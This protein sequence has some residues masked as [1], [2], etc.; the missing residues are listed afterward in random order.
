MNCLDCLSGDYYHGYYIGD[1]KYFSVSERTDLPENILLSTPL[2]DPNVMDSF[3]MQF[4]FFDPVNIRIII[5]M[6]ERHDIERGDM[7]TYDGDFEYVYENSRNVALPT[8][9]IPGVAWPSYSDLVPADAPEYTN[10]RIRAID[11][12]TFS[13]EMRI[14]IDRTTLMDF[15][16][17]LDNLLQ[18]GWEPH[19]WA[20]WNTEE[21]LREGL[22]GEGGQYSF[23]NM[24]NEYILYF[25]IINEIQG[26]LQQL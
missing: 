20:N 6:S 10:G 22:S 5:D 18:D 9:I 16:E 13:H 12:T 23:I 24:D 21:A 1:D 7:Y 25:H 15:A 19:G 3:S 8:H 11:N 17:Y 14:Y 2:I 4:E 26:K